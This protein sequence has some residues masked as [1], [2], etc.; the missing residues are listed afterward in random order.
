MLIFKVLEDYVSIPAA[1][2]KMIKEGDKNG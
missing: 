2:A 1:E